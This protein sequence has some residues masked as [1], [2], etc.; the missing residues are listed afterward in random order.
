MSPIQILLH[1]KIK[2]KIPQTILIVAIVGLVKQFRKWILRLNSRTLT[3][4]IKI[5]IV[6]L[7]I[8][9]FGEKVYFPYR[10]RVLVAELAAQTPLIPDVSKKLPSVS[11]MIPCIEKDLAF[12]TTCIEGVRK[13]VINPVDKISVVTNCPDLVKSVVEPGIE[14]ISETTFLPQT[15]QD[16]IIN[17]IPKKVQG[18]VSKQI[19][20]MYFAYTSEQHG[21]LTVDADTILLKPRI[22]LSHKKQILSPVVEY[23]QHDA[24]T[25]HKTWNS[26]GLSM[27]ISFKAHHMLM[28]PKTVREMFDSLGGFEPGSLKWLA[29]TLNDEWLPFSEFHSY[30]T[31]MLNR[32]PGQVEFARWGN[33]RISRSGI[34]ALLGSSSST[35]FYNKL[36][37]NYSTCNSVSFHHYLPK[38]FDEWDV[39]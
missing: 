30:A 2:T 12:L 10:M 38:D 39:P 3:R 23:L 5:I 18:W 17:N 11:V 15:I 13:N 1:L 19:I 37:D 8:G 24:Q 36:Q 4:L 22:F 25:T 28:K 7:R 16:F 26:S 32:Y 33:K 6:S 21:V 27:G 9:R 14:I 31:W 35:N 29:S 20:V 34:A